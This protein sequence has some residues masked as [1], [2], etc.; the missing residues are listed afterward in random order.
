MVVR[1]ISRKVWGVRYYMRRC[2]FRI[3]SNV[4]LEQ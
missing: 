4:N 2:S 1:N 3:L